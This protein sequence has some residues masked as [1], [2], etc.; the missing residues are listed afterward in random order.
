MSKQRV[1]ELLN[2]LPDEDFVELVLPQVKS[3][4]PLVD[5]LV[6]GTSGFTDVYWQFDKLRRE[7]CLR[8]PELRTQLFPQAGSTQ[9]SNLTSSKVKFIKLARKHMRQS[10]EWFLDIDNSSHFRDALMSE[11]PKEKKAEFVIKMYTGIEGEFNMFLRE[12]LQRM[13]I[14]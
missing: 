14:E 10:C 3:I 9:S 7:L 13:E 2:A 1:R 5:F 8:Y 4:V 11:L 12:R 6:N